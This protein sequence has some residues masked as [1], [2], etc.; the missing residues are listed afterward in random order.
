FSGS[1][2][3]KNPGSIFKIDTNYHPQP[4][5]TDL[6]NAAGLALDAGGGLYGLSRHD[7]IIYQ[8]F[9]AGDLATYVEGMGGATGIVFD[10]EGNLYVG[11]RSGT[12][13]KISRQ[14][15]IYVFAT[16][17]PSIAAY[18]L[19]FGANDYLYVTGPTTSSF[20]SLHR[21]SRDGHVETFYRGLGR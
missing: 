17:E 15:Q 6:M 20:D 18:H 5:G 10:Q 3:Q 16:L 9:P 14:R 8:V 12:I 7:G 4:L 21:I 19:A 13:F 2:G 1:A 11:D